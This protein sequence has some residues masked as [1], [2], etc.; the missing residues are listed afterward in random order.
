MP[1]LKLKKRTAVSREKSKQYDPPKKE[2]G[3]LA[4]LRPSKMMTKSSTGNKNVPGSVWAH[5]G[6]MPPPDWGSAKIYGDMGR[7]SK[8]SKTTF[9][10]TIKISAIN[11]E[12]VGNKA[13]GRISK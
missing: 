1:F 8:F 3:I 9:H 12:V 11:G 4:V 2:T 5:G 6:R 10:K 7:D 13:K